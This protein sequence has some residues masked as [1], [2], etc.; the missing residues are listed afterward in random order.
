MPIFFADHFKKQLKK[1]KK[2]YPHIKEDLLGVLERLDLD[3]EIAPR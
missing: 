2:K 1:L 3:Q